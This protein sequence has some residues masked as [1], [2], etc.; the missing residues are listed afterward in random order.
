M[1]AQFQNHMILLKIKK[2][3]CSYGWWLIKPQLPTCMFPEG[4]LEVRENAAIFH[5]GGHTLWLFSSCWPFRLAPSVWWYWHDSSRNLFASH[6]LLKQDRFHWIGG[7]TIHWHLSRSSFYTCLC[8]QIHP[9]HLLWPAVGNTVG[10]W[11]YKYSLKKVVILS[12][13]WI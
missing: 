11:A 4:F 7:K 10:T 9:V 3:S 6:S 12:R 1:Y 8:P 2:P 5:F 13:W